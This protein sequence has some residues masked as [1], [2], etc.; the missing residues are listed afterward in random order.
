MFSVLIRMFCLL[1]SLICCSDVVR[2]FIST[3]VAVQRCRLIQ[4]VTHVV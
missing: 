1:I 2:K 3:I 4:P